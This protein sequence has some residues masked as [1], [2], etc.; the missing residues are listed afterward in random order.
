MAEDKG[1]A[2][3]SGK[4]VGDITPLCVSDI[5]GPAGEAD[6]AALEL[7]FGNGV[8]FCGAKLRGVALGIEV[9][10]PGDDSG[11]RPGAFDVGSGGEADSSAAGAP[12]IG[13]TGNPE[14]LFPIGC[15]GV[16]CEPPV[17]GT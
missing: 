7:L 9:G 5:D 2:D 10:R 12:L 14:L 1:D 3:V 4:V 11:N 15:F 6:P 13:N 17:L 16:A 8:K